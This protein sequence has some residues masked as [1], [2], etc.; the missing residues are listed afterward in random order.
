M[1]MLLCAERCSAA[2][3]DGILVKM[4]DPG[5][6]TISCLIGTQKFVQALCDLRA[7]M[8]VMPKVIYDQLNHDSLVPTSMYLQLADQLIWC[9]VGIV[10]DIP[11]RIRN[12]FVPVDFMVLKMDVCHQTLLTLGMPFLS[13]T[14]ATIDV[15]ARIIKLNI[16]GKEET[17]TFK[18]S[19]TEQCN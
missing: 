3:L 13:T 7:S 4:G 18:P 2:I 17:F 12:S 9:P 11:M 1:D 10:E 16:T 6:P 8:S 19:D 15:V 5:V 14:G